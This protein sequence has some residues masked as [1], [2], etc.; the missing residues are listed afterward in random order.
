MG[1]YGRLL[2]PWWTGNE[3]VTR[4][5]AVLNGVRVKDVTAPCYGTELLDL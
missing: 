1:R 3:L 2:R 4:L 5:V